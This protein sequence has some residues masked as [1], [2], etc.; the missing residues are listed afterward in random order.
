MKVQ[1]K[2]KTGKLKMVSAKDAELLEQINMAKIVRQ[3]PEK[4]KINEP[5][6]VEETT[7]SSDTRRQYQRRDMVAEGQQKNHP[8]TSKEKKD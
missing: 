5:P 3:R 7:N 6:A 4:Q 1:V 8:A 2:Y